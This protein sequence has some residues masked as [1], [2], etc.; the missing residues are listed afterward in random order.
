MAIKPWTAKRIF[1]R[2]QYKFKVKCV[3]KDF[4]TTDWG[5]QT[6]A[7]SGIVE[8]NERGNWTAD[9]LWSYALHEAWHVKAFREG[10]F[11]AYHGALED[12]KDMTTNE[13]KRYIL[14]AYR[15]EAYI[16]K[17]ASETFQEMNPGGLYWWSYHLGDSKNHAWFQ[18]SE[19]DPYRKELRR[20][21]L[22]K[23]D[24]RKREAEKYLAFL[25]G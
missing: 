11:A 4:G 6:D 24:K 17:K 19:V 21:T 9:K 20:R 8:I 25:P 15:A 10:T 1:Q 7:I 5:G 23:I 13:L 12:P 14:T 3:M 18:E 22:R 16:E 2:I